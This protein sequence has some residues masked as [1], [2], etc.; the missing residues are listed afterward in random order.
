MKRFNLEKYGTTV[1]QEV[2]AGLISFFAVSYIIVVN[3]LIL[4][5][6]GMPPELTVFATIFIGAVGSLLMGWWANTPL[7]VAPGMGENAFFTF[8]AVAALGLAW[9]ESLTVVLISGVLFML[10]V[11]SG[12]MGKFTHAIPSVLKQ[13][14]TVGIGLFL[15]L[16]GLQNSGLVIDGG[17][18]GIVA[19]GDLG[20]PMT[21]LALGGLVF[22]AV[23]FMKRVPGSFFLS[24]AVITVLSLVLGIHQPE[25]TAFSLGNIAQFPDLW[26]SYDFSSVFTFESLLAI[27]SLTMLLV[28]E[29][30]GMVEG[31][32][33]DP[34][35]STR[36][37]QVMSGMAVVSSFLG[38]S[39]PIPAAES[40]SG[41]KE[42][43]R[44]GLTAVTAGILFLLALVLTP[45]LAYIPNAA[46][47]PVIVITGASMMENLKFISFD[48]FSEWFPAFLII[49]MMTFTG[50]IVN[51][52]AFG[53]V[54]Y[55]VL[56]AAKGERDSLN[57]TLLT[58]SF[59]F[60]LTLAATV[61]I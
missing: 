61:F 38:S 59:L 55:P 49:V 20:N 12:L 7:I 60:L 33:N 32:L 2:L 24:I 22:T 30:I 50:S 36:S 21:A 53:F 15:V 43:G 29:A 5:E 17:E 4:S 14:I 6:T 25:P 18:S 16:I 41:I 44:T 57:P 42:G 23:L 11:F 19:L 28:F 48:D 26:G 35:W 13:A 9:Q 1:R 8:T 40:A 37:F 46:L 10:I 45:L 51:G 31:L 3:P 39:P 34:S 58:V 47:A 56:K 27:F 52:M 54:A